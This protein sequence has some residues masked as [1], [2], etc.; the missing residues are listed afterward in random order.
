VLTLPKR[1]FRLG[2][3]ITGVFRFLQPKMPEDGADT[4]ALPSCLKVGSH[5]TKPTLCKLHVCL[6]ALQVAIGLQ[7]KETIGAGARIPG[8]AIKD[9]STMVVLDAQQ[10]PTINAVTS[11]F[12]LSAPMVAAPSFYCDFGTWRW[13]RG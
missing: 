13:R 5:P 11:G 8:L 4:S 2:E 10:L 12:T 6:V 3:D 1:R 7:R 9:S